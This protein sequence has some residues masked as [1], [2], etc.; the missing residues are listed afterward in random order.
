MVNKRK[1]NESG[2]ATRKD[3]G[4]RLNEKKSVAETKD[5]SKKAYIKEEADI[6]N[7]CRNQG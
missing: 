6:G 4:K 1:I 2:N 5:K 3:K 7:C